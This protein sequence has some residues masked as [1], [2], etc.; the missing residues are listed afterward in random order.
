MLELELGQLQAYKLQQT[1]QVKGTS[2]MLVLEEITAMREVHLLDNNRPIL[3]LTRMKTNFGTS[4]QMDQDQLEEVKVQEMVWDKE[5]DVRVQVPIITTT[6]DN[7]RK[8]KFLKKIDKYR[9]N[10]IFQ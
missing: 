5:L 9:K 3:E 4:N 8:I 2:I 6:D 7:D 10:R 1:F